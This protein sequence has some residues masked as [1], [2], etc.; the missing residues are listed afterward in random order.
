MSKQDIYK[1]LLQS[2]MTQ[3]AVFGMMGNMK[4][5]SGLEAG[6]VQGDFSPFRTIS[7]SYCT[8][9]E[10]G[11]LTKEAFIRDGLGFGLVQLTFW[12]RKAD[13]Y[14]FWKASGKPVDDPVLQSQFVVAE[15]KKNYR[16]LWNELLISH[17]LYT[18]TKII[19]EQ[20]ERPAHNNISDR[21]TAAVSL[22]NELAEK[23]V[24][25]P[26]P[27]GEVYWPPR[28]ICKG[29][30]GY[31]VIVLQAILKA[32]GFDCET[33]SGEFN[34]RTKNRVLAYQGENNLDT[35]GIVGPLTWKSLL[36]C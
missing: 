25:E 30:S 28:M 5:E 32:R 36:S 4:C 19:C 22:K 12:S 10:N 2:G 1:T 15:L 6:R 16:N 11:S 35:D 14:D 13:Y 7:K 24:D 29:M 27:T 17:D 34:E 18:C 26:K 3:E 31:D 8:R 20:Y 21:F 9:L 33:L 23:M